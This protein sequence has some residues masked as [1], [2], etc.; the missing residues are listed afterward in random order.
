MIKFSKAIVICIIAGLISSCSQILETV[1]LQVNTEDN[2]LQEN[3]NV[4]EKTLVIEEARKQSNAPYVREV[5]INGRGGNARSVPENFALISKFPKSKGPFKYKIGIGDILTY[6]RLIDNTQN[7]SDHDKKWPTQPSPAKY[8]LGI[9]DTLTLTLIKEEKTTNQIPSNSGEGNQNMI[10]TSQQ[11][12]ITINSVGRIGSDGSVLLLEIG[13][14]EASGKSLNELRSEVRNILIRNGTSPRFQLEISDF[15][16]QRAYLTVYSSQNTA[17]D[18]IN[19]NDQRTTLLDILTSARIAFKPGL[20]TT[21]K[22]RRENDIFYMK[23]RDIFTTGAP[24]IQILDRD[25]IFVEENSAQKATSLSKVDQGGNVVF[26]GIGK[27]KAA[28]RSLDELRNE[29]DKFLAKVPGSNN[30]FQLEITEFLSQ[31]ALVIIP[32]ASNNGITIPITNNPLTLTEV[33]TQNGLRI[34]ANNIARINLRRDGVTY[35]FTLDDL[36]DPNNSNLYLRPRDRITTD[37]LPYKDN[38]VFILGGVSPKIFKINPTNRETLADALFTEGGA[39]STSTAKRSEVY[40]LRGSDPVVAYHLDAQSPTRL[41]VAEAMELRPNDILY[42]AEQP[43][44][45]FNRTLAT[46]IPL[47]VLIR[48]IQDENIP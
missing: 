19:L 18:I 20:I 40:L 39:L 22:L 41:I 24:Q 6:S 9:G 11:K 1:E 42:I 47:R 32:G 15:K 25:H 3:F 2:S 44:I 4:I 28:G 13:R 35:V 10:I 5:L 23:L 8:K 45:S 48:D 43:I 7:F 17:S 21:V 36:L 29:I 12:D 33:L 37:I 14:L 31:T 34:D 46:I 27:I 30:A 26:E 38:K 16:S